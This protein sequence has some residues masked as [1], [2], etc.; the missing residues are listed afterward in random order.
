MTSKII[1]KPTEYSSNKL[2]LNDYKTNG[3]VSIKNLF[4]LNLISKLTQ[5]LTKSFQILLSNKLTLSENIIFLNST[6]KPKLYHYHNATIKLMAHNILANDIY[7]VLDI[8]NKK[9]LYS[10]PIF[11]ICLAF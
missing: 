5:D 11:I 6:D 7:L 8:L 4:N 9:I 2:L 3:Y 1:I 10:F